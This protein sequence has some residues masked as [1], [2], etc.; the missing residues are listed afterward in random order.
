MSEFSYGFMLGV[1][2][3]LTPSIVV[4]ALILWDTTELEE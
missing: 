3:V 4:M 1:M 2:V